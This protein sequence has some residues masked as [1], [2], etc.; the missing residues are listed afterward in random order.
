MEEVTY[1]SRKRGR[2]CVLTTSDE[3]FKFGQIPASNGEMTL[4]A[5]E[6]Q[7]LFWREKF[8]AMQKL[9]DEAEEDLQSLLTLK[10]QSDEAYLLRIK[11]LEDE[12]LSTA[13]VEVKKTEQDDS[14]L[15]YQKMTGMRVK[16][17]GDKRVCIF[18]NSNKEKKIE[19]TIS[20]NSATDEYE[21]EPIGDASELPEYMQSAL[22]FDKS[23]APA[24][25]ADVLAA[26]H[27]T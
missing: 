15:F 10:R 13:S 7:S 2:E 12:K 17:L 14:I 21:Y 11:L 27:P 22:A 26:L 24:L 9:K 23:M 6:D 19:F 3:N 1:N 20:E 4:S 18:F 16:A 5:K 8:F 25:V